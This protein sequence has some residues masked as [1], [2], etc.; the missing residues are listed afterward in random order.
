MEKVESEIPCPFPHHSISALPTFLIALCTPNQ[1]PPLTNLLP[2]RMVQHLDICDRC[3]GVESLRDRH[4]STHPCEHCLD[5]P[6]GD[7]DGP[8]SNYD[9]C[10]IHQLQADRVAHESVCRERQVKRWL[11]RVAALCGIVFI[12][13]HKA[14][15]DYNIISSS[16]KDDKSPYRDI[17][18][19]PHSPFSGANWSWPGYLQEEDILGAV[20][21]DMCVSGIVLQTPLLAWALEGTSFIHS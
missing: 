19:A 16:L 15:F 8:R 14:L 17:N 10:C 20:S 6:D 4:I 7:I 2:N 21:F 3:R 12:S 1:R 13:V 5:V 9:Y 11:V 18:L